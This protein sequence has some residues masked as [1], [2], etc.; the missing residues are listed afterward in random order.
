MMCWQETQRE[1]DRI[2]ARAVAAAERQVDDKD[3]R[4][5]D[6]TARLERADKRLCWIVEKWTGY[7]E[8]RT[9]EITDPLMCAINVGNYRWA[10]AEIDA[11]LAK[12]E[13][14]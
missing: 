14:K 11:A 2:V 4:I 6:L 7:D 8:L 5:A 13:Q 3:A 1:A 12:G 9:R 10:V